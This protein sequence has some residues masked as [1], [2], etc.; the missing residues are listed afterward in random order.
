VVEEFYP[1]TGGE[2]TSPIETDQVDAARQEG[3]ARP[4]LG[5]KLEARAALLRH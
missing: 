2:A 1:V 3:Q 5:S 4:T